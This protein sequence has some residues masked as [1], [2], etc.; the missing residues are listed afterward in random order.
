MRGEALGLGEGAGEQDVGGRGH[1]DA[2]G[3][4]LVA[5]SAAE[6][7]Q[8]GGVHPA[9]G[10]GEQHERRLD[11]SGGVGGLSR[12]GPG[13]RTR[14]GFA[15]HP[16][17]PVRARGGVG[18]RAVDGSR[19]GARGRCGDALLRSAVGGCGLRVRAGGRGLACGRGPVGE[20]RRR[21]GPVCGVGGRAVGRGPA[22]GRRGRLVRG[23][24]GGRVRGPL[25]VGFGCGG[26]CAARRC[27][28]RA[29]GRHRVRGRRDGR[30]LAAGLTRGG[31]R[32]L[33]RGGG[34]GG[35]QAEGRQEGGHRRFVA[36]RGVGAV[37]LDRDS[38]RDQGAAHRREGAS[39][40]ADQD[41]HVLPGHAVLQVGPAQD[42]GD[43][44]QLG[45]GRRVREDL[46]PAALP[47]GPQG[48]VLADRGR[49]EAGQRHAGG[50]EAGRRQEGGAGAAAHRQG[51]DLRSGEGG[52]EVQHV[53]DVGAAEGVD[54]LVGVAEGDQRAA[55]PGQGPQ[56]PQLR[57]VR[58][59]VLVHEDRVVGRNQR[60][61]PLGE[62]DRTVQEFRVVQ[63][64]L[65]VEDVE[66]LGEEG[67]R[68][69]PVGAADAVGEVGEGRRAE[70]QLTGAGEDRADLV[71]EAA[72]GQR[73]PQ[74]VR[75][76]DRADPAL[77]LQEG[78]DH[79][80]LLGAGQQPQ[81]VGEEVGVL[82]GAD[83]AVAE[84]VEGGGLRGARAAEPQ[85][86]P[87]AQFDGRLAA[88]GEDQ[89]P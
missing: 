15:V 24:G 72:R 52:L 31:S 87:V 13:S 83:Q 36:E 38:R 1:L 35:R 30:P 23:G 19:Q 58:V 41:G 29:R 47:R 8:I 27:G 69:L 3:A 70:A 82:V 44:V 37:R 54:R 45:A 89:D 60:R 33:R 55:V 26:R 62:E 48:A 78:A 51:P 12:A 43:V 9:E 4:L 28:G 61:R 42:V 76:A 71:G 66:V 22:R 17:V 40:G 57:G 67:R 77:A 79:H 16:A 14:A 59:L 65:Y 80:V 21:G 49:R 34:G 25:R 53:V 5:Q 73:G 10:R 88:E 50:Q 11:A 63:G 2:R 75:P 18:A 20:V 39:A 46:D 85:G 56:Q 6:P 84:G 68:G 32:R 64:A 74:V 86:G 81:R 7:P